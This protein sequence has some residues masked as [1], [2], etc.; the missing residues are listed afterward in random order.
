MEDEVKEFE[1][2]YKSLLV[3]SYPDILDILLE[4]LRISNEYDFDEKFVI[5]EKGVFNQE[6][7]DDYSKLLYYLA[8]YNAVKRIKK[9]HSNKKT[10]FFHDS[11][12]LG[13]NTD[14]LNSYV[15]LFPNRFIVHTSDFSFHT[16]VVIAET[17]KKVGYCFNMGVDFIRQ[18]IRHR[19]LIRQE[20]F[21]L[22]PKSIFPYSK[23]HVDIPTFV[24]FRNKCFLDKMGNRLE[25]IPQTDY[26]NLVVELPWLK[27][28]RIED[29][30]E[31]K[32]KYK[33][34]YERFQLKTDELMCAAQSGTSIESILAKE[35]NEASLE[36]RRIILNRKSEMNRKGKEVAVGIIC[37]VIPI[38][39]NQVGIN[40][41]DSQTVGA[42]IGGT[43]IYCGIKE[44]FANHRTE[45]DNPYWILYKWQQKVQ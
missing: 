44:F 10:V 32:E 2:H 23:K 28:A 41:L 3:L 9:V 43:T 40:L 17:G 31:L 7:L 16:K 1:D 29:F 35:Y 27:N 22:F 6:A 21:Y 13:T 33:L 8:C 4:H 34:E 25:I 20:A 39:L 30:I 12:S 37:T 19:E 14:Y 18:Y 42:V 38:A 36:I 24:R 11:L 45:K 26:K 15:S 5:N